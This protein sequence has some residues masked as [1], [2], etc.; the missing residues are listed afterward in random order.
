[1]GQGD[2]A[3]G[4]DLP[5]EDLDRFGVSEDDLIAGNCSQPFQELMRFEG[6][7]A[8]N[9]YREAAAALPAADRRS[10]RAAELMR[11]IYSRILSQM[12]ADGYRVFEKRYRLGKLEMLGRLL[13]AKFFG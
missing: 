5:L 7:R 3:A 2:G 9:W 8:E 6:E 12:K 1:M 10:M 13:A 4:A 11:S